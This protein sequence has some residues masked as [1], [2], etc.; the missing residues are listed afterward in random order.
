VGE[1]EIF[2]YKALT[3]RSAVFSKRERKSNFQVM[4]VEQVIAQKQ[5]AAAGMIGYNLH[6]G[7]PIRA[8]PR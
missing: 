8:H 5:A 7:T 2:E 4:P 1:G 6:S 3:V